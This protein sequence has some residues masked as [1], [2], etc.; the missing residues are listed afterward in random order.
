LLPYFK[1]TENYH[2]TDVDTSRHGYS[3]PLYTQSITTSGRVYSLRENVL[4]SWEE[5]GVK[6]IADANSGS[7]QGISELVEN[8]SDG[9]R[10]VASDVY[11]LEGV[12]VLTETVVASV[13]IESDGT[14]KTAKGVKLANGREFLAKEEVIL[15]AGALATPLLSGIGAA[16]DLAEHGIEQVVDLPEVGRNFHGH[17]CV[18]Q[19]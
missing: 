13:I 17:M 14:S 10:Q 4:K 5:V 18:S 19:W 9:V 15:S 7:P 12:C 6:R 11:P 16:E 3:G 1:R 2:T 8:L